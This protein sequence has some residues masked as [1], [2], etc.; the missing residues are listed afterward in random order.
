MSQGS[1][2]VFP[3]IGVTAVLSRLTAVSRASRAG[4][5]VQELGRRKS[6]DYTFYT[7]PVVLCAPRFNLPGHIGAVEGAEL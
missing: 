7:G 4:L 5:G 1:L 6:V 3:Q 2:L